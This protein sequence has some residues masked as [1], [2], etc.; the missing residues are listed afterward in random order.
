MCLKQLRA[1]ERPPSFRVF[2][3]NPDGLKLR[4]IYGDVKRF[5]SERLIFST[6][7]LHG[8]TVQGMGEGEEESVRD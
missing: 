6:N 8:N 5:Y 2:V 4:L 7:G 1:T 3:V